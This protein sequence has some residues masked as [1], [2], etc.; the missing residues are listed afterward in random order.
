LLGP[1]AKW[2]FFDLFHRLLKL[3]LGAYRGFSD[4]FSRKV[5]E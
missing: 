3:R 2:G 5:G 4:S 1:A